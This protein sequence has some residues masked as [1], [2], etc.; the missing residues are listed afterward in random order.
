MA[1]VALSAKKGRNLLVVRPRASDLIEKVFRSV[2]WVGVEISSTHPDLKV[3]NRDRQVVYW[4]VL[5]FL[6]C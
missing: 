3:W 6:H 1:A 2:Q 5:L 4:Q